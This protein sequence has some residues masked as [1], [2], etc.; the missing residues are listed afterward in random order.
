LDHDTTGPVNISSGTR[1]T[2]RHLVESIADLMAY[3][4]ALV[5]D[6]SKPD[7]QMVKV[8]DVTEMRRLGLSCPTP[9]RDGLRRT[10]EWVGRHYD[11]RSDGIRL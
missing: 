7:G 3:D 2:I 10:I 9:L 1:V 11:A 5:W 4:G 8:F 6:T